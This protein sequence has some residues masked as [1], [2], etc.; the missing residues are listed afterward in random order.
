MLGLIWNVEDY[1][2]SRTFECETAWE[3][4]MRD[5]NW[6]FTNDNAPRFKDGLWRCV[7][8]P[9]NEHPFDAVKERLFREIFWEDREGLWKRFNTL[10]YIANQGEKE[11]AVC[12]TRIVW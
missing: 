10:S 4:S 1:N 9:G 8:A 11:K 12:L 3:S 7:F 2:Q 5:L 6:Q